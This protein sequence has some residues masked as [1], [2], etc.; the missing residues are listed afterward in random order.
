MNR[1]F[2]FMKKVENEMTKKV[3]FRRK[4]DTHNTCA[5]PFEVYITKRN[6]EVN[7]ITRYY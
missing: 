5:Y 7:P 2:S 1:H 6:E 3:C 4:P